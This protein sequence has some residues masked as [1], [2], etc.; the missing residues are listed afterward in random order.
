M[1][2]GVDLVRDGKAE[3]GAQDHSKATYEGWCRCD[4]VRI[5]WHLPL[6]T[7]WNLIRGANPQPG[8]WTTLGDVH[9]SIF[10]CVKVSEAKSVQPGKVT[11]VGEDGIT[12]AAADGQLLVKRLKSAGGKKLDAAEWAA[13]TGIKEGAKFV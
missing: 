7:T 9:V 5:N 6:Q 10:D 13:E 11:A 3:K 2:E 8:A 4:L 1:L 12:V